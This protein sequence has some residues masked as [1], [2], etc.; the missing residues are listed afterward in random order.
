MW[1][2]KGKEFTQEDAEAFV[3]KSRT[4]G[5]VY[6][7]TNKED[8]KK[9]LGKK[10][11]TKKV[12]RNPLKGKKAK[13]RSYP[14]SDW[15][16]YV[17]S[18]TETMQLK[19]DHGLDIFKREILHLCTMKGQLNYM[20]AKEQFD[21]DVLLRDDYYNGIIAC[22]INHTHVKVLKEQYYEMET[23]KDKTS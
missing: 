4:C 8:G 1:L 3:G 5:F 14:P 2:Y 9:Y 12:T 23:N 18:N 7:I 19:E 21:R 20:E 11:F 6:L 15:P 22:R 13:R 10:N 16:D 17:G